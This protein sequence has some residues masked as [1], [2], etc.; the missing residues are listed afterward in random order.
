MDAVKDVFKKWTTWAI[1]G[2]KSL[3]VIP[4]QNTNSTS[5]EQS[6]NTE[7]PMIITPIRVVKKL[8]IA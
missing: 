7:E 8:E 3:P 6:L 5:S 1:T 4:I 2:A